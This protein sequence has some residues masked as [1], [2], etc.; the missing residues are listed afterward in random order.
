MRVLTHQKFV[1]RELEQCHFGGERQ[2]TGY[3]TH[4][5]RTRVTLKRRRFTARVHIAVHNFSIDGPELSTSIV[6]S[7]DVGNIT[8]KK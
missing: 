2:Q 5:I 3:Q 4:R 6:R 1:E 7:M 8:K